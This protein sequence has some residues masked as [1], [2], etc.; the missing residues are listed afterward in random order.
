M[1]PDQRACDTILP[2]QE[3]KGNREK[4]LK[5]L[6]ILLIRMNVNTKENYPYKGIRGKHNRKYI[7][8]AN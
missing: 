1:C 8:K 5:Y 7:T 3:E 4:I 2:D 6:I